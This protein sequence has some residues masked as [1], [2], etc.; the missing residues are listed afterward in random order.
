MRK[1]LLL[2][3]FFTYSFTFSQTTEIVK[4]K[5]QRF[6]NTQK[7]LVK[8]SSIDQNDSIFDF[9]SIKKVELAPNCPIN[10]SKLRN[11]DNRALLI[12]NWYLNYPTEYKN[13]VEFLEKYIRSNH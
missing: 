3:F 5:V 7:D 8:I 1:L 2:M 4:R 10:P 6:E 13:Y 11:E 12:E 9:I